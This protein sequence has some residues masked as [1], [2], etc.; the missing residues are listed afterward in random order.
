[1]REF[2][3]RLRGWIDSHTDQL[4]VL[5]SLVVGCWLVGKSPYLIVTAWRSPGG[6]SCAR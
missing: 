1:M 3:A 4:I 5:V 2:L 6:R